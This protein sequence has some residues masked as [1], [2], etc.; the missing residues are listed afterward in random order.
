[1]KSELSNIFTGTQYEKANRQ[2]I[3]QERNPISLSEIAA[4]IKTQSQ[5]IVQESIDEKRNAKRFY[6]HTIRENEMPTKLQDRKGIILSEICSNNGN[7][8]PTVYN[9]AV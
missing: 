6:R 8:M 3:L 1:M 9:A 4:T 2:T 7:E 5:T